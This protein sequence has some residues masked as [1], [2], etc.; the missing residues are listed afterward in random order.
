MKLALLLTL[1]SASSMVYSYRDSAGVEHFVQSADQVPAGQRAKAIDL[2]GE[3]LNRDL[4]GRWERADQAS[5]SR[6]IRRAKAEAPAPKPPPAHSSD[7]GMLFL[8]GG[9]VLLMLLPGLILGWAR[10]PGRKLLLWAALADGIAGG[11]L[12]AIGARSLHHGAPELDLNPLHAVSNAE[13]A[14]HD[15]EEAER[16]QEQAAEQLLGEKPPAAPT[17]R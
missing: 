10:A 8:V 14:R 13:R 9:G 16:R 5:A 12:C 3:R 17:R 6:L 4:E 2:S 15:V 7:R 11:S 1:L